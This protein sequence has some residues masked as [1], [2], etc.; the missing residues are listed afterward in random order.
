MT[1]TPRVGDTVR[2]LYSED[3]RLVGTMA[4]VIGVD[5]YAASL[6]TTLPGTHPNLHD[7]TLCRRMRFDLLQVVSTDPFHAKVVD[8]INRELGNNG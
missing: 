1:Q 6:I 4:K 7:G 3:R 8:Y 5:S 2:I